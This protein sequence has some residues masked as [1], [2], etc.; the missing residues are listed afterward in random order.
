MIS[1][2]QFR[3][4]PDILLVHSPQ[5]STPHS[6]HIHM[7][8]GLITS[9][10]CHVHAGLSSAQWFPSPQASRILSKDTR[11][12]LQL[13]SLLLYHSSAIFPALIFNSIKFISSLG[14]HIS[15]HPPGPSRLWLLTR[16]STVSY[17]SSPLKAV[18]PLHI[19]SINNNVSYE[20]EVYVHHQIHSTFNSTSNSV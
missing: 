5:F 6:M 17:T 10:S 15:R 11:L 14:D 1:P 9:M 18:S 3:L 2:F 4:L 13:G 12:Y 16:D 7:R 20:M 8:F 19:S